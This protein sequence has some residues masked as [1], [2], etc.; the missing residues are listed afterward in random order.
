M[1]HDDE[2]Y[3]D[4]STVEKNKSEIIPEQTPE[5]PYGS[6]I[7]GTLQKTTAWKDGQRSASAFTYENRNLHQDL[8][9]KDPGS[10]PTHDD[11][12]IDREEPFKP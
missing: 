11:K 10:H 2:Y 6:P 3:T 5:G 7:K 9:R 8:E 4:F 1:Y 12:R